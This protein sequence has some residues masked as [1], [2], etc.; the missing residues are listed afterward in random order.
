MQGHED[1]AADGQGFEFFGHVGDVVAIK[2]DVNVVPAR[3]G[4]IGLAVADHDHAL[5]NEERRMH[6]AVLVLGYDFE[7]G[8][9][10][11]AHDSVGLG[12]EGA[13]VEV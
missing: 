10:A 7:I 9:V 4:F 2:W 11:K 13:L 5:S 1:L 3:K 12:A 8:D 6:H